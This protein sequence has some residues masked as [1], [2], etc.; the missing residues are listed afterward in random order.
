[1][2]HV[3]L[4]IALMML[5]GCAAVR[6]QPR[7]FADEGGGAPGG[8]LWVP[9]PGIYLA[10]AGAPLGGND[11][12]VNNLTV[13]GT[14]ALRGNVTITGNL[15]FGANAT[16]DIGGTGARV[17]RLYLDT[18]VDNNTAT[19]LAVTAAQLNLYV[20]SAANTTTL[21]DHVFTTNVAKT[22]ATRLV[23]ACATGASGACTQ[24]WSIHNSGKSIQATTDSTGTPGAA[25][26]TTPTG[27]FAIAAG[28]G[29]AGTTI[30]STSDVVTTASIIHAVLQ[31]TDATCTFIKSVIPGAGSFV[32][33]TNANCTADTNVGFVVFN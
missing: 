7:P 29:A 3:R 27:Q 13:L 21:T 2:Q 30:T 16:Y 24:L 4:A 26:I 25:T 23:G 20:G 28:A 11:A 9:P 10:Q 12:T 1:M 32:V 17:R 22:G 14:S 31:E 33:T 8:G 6:I 15:A 5:S 19:R 18:W